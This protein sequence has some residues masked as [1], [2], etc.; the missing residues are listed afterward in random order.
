MNSLTILEERFDY[1]L[2]SAPR[3]KDLSKEDRIDKLYNWAE[4]FLNVLLIHDLHESCD[5]YRFYG[6]GEDRI[7]SKTEACVEMFEAIADVC[8][9][10]KKNSSVL[11]DCSYVYTPSSVMNI[12]DDAWNLSYRKDSVENVSWATMLT[13]ECIVELEE[14]DGNTTKTIKVLVFQI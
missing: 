12:L 6:N 3:V 10:V 4:G 8:P 1:V 11:I 5:R 7:A 2:F 14:K 13:D 9:D